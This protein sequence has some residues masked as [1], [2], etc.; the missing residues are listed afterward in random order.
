MITKLIINIGLNGFAL[1]LLTY[2]I[3]TITYTGGIRF[4]IIGGIVLGIFN[5]VIRPLLKILALPFILFASWLVLILINI[6][7]LIFI[8]YFF[9]FIEFR[10]I[11]FQIQG[12][13][14]YIIGA[15]VFGVINWILNFLKK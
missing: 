8:D 1:F 11:S 10:D 2:F 3:E 7:L 12:I 4:F 6:I 5:F 13:E 14:N 9:E 15:I